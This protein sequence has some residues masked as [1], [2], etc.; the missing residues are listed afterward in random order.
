MRNSRRKTAVAVEMV[1]DRSGRGRC[2]ASPFLIAV[3]GV[4]ASFV[5]G[6]LIAASLWSLV[7]AVIGATGGIRAGDQYRRGWGYGYESAARV[8]VERPPGQ[9]GAVEPRVSVHDDRTPGPW[10]WRIPVGVVWGGR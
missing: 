2:W 9:A 3:V 7:V 5:P 6:E 1:R 4:L 8:K 10:E